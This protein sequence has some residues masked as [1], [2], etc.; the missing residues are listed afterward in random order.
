M[1]FGVPAFAVI[2]KLLKRWV[3]H[4]LR[5]KGIPAGTTEFRRIVCIDEETERPVYREAAE[6]E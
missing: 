1:L 5:R 2:Y 4:S 6:K 3:E